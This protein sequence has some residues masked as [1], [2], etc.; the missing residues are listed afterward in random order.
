MLNTYINQT[1]SKGNPFEEILIPLLNIPSPDSNSN[2]PS[3][4]LREPLLQQLYI[5]LQQKLNIP[6]ENFER[7]F[8]I[9]LPHCI[10]TIKPRKNANVEKTIERMEQYYLELFNF[11]QI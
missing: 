5:R 1:L 11:T 2:A 10:L 3:Y 8:L 9:A 6:A 4:Q 7:L